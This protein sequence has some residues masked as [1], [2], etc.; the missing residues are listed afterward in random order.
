MTPARETRGPKALWHLCQGHAIVPLH[1]KTQSF[2]FVRLRLSPLALLCAPPL[3]NPPPIMVFWGREIEAEMRR[4][5]AGAVTEP[6]CVPTTGTRWWRRPQRLLMKSVAVFFC[7]GENVL[8]RRFLPA[9]SD[10]GGAAHRYGAVLRYDKKKEITRRSGAPGKSVRDARGW[11]NCAQSPWQPLYHAAA[12]PAANIGQINSS[13]YLS[14]WK[15]RRKKRP[16]PS[17]QKRATSLVCE[18]QL[19]LYQRWM[20]SEFLSSNYI[21]ETVFGRKRM[22]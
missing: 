5:D 15:K 11:A 8:R 18:N 13:A 22:V 6:W 7:G 19:S 21:C 20:F 2:S 9:T 14:F 12:V 17:P 16:M 1:H 3:P 10:I 4:Q